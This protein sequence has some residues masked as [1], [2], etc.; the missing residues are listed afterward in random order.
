MNT[1]MRNL[2]AY[3]FEKLAEL[4]RHS[5]VPDIEA[6]PLTIGEPQHEPPQQVLIAL[7]EA[8][9]GAGK[10]PSIAG[11]PPLRQAIAS[12]LTN[13]FHTR[14]IDPDHEVLPVNGTR[15]GLFA[16]AQALT[17]GCDNPRIALP[18]PFYQIYEGAALLAGAIPLFIAASEESGYLANY[19]HMS[20]DKWKACNLLF[21]CTPGNP[22]GRVIPMSDLQLLIEK[23]LEHD[24]VLVSDECYS[25]LYF[26]EE[27]PPT[28]LLEAAHAMGNTELKQCLA[29]HSLSK[30]SNL[31][32]LRSGFVAGDASLIETFKR[33]RTYHGCAMPLHHQAASTVAWSDETHVLNNRELYRQKFAAVLPILSEHLD[34]GQP[35]AGFYLWPR[36]HGDDQVFARSLLEQQNVRV[37]PGSYL[38]REVDGTNPGSGHVRIALVSTLQQTVEAAERVAL[39]LSRQAK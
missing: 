1:G 24:V 23:A 37:L 8:L 21:L 39:F 29:F 25:E 6:I 16:I 7:T 11:T 3:P 9:A 2:Q 22:S 17:A 20:D 27:Y 31:P 32:G 33:Y 15:E 10:Y 36:I 38:G 12:W 4:T 5:I 13:R 34:V 18:N 26:D 14:A 35:D 30:R 28:G 19:Q